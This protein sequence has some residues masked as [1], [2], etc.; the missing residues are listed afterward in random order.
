MEYM[1]NIKISALRRGWISGA[2]RPGTQIN[3]GI[4]F[5]K[6]AHQAQCA[7]PA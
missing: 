1:K 7:V 5:V 2:G 4:F 3:A 6:Q